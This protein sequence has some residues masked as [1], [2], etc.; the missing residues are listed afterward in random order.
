MW[1][2]M[3][4]TSRLEM[5]RPRPV[6]PYWRVVEESACV[7]LS[8]MTSSLSAGMPMPVS[9]TEQQR[10]RL[11]GRRVVLD[12]QDDLTGH[13]ELERVAYQIQEDLPQAMWV[14][15]QIARHI[16]HDLAGQLEPL[17]MGDL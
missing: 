3:S 17:V 16:R 12:S 14:A 8:K 11:L 13:R 4:S 5:V 1:P 2:P 7:K 15:D 9:E 10:A 6:P